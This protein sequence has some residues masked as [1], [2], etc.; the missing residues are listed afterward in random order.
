MPRVALSAWVPVPVFIEDEFVDRHVRIGAD[1]E[2]GF[3]DE[4]D[5]RLAVRPG[6]DAF[7][8]DD[9]LADHQPLHLT[10]RQRAAD[11]GVDGAADADPLLR[12]GGQR[13]GGK[14]R[15]NQGERTAHG[16]P[17]ALSYLQVTATTEREFVV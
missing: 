6:R 17:P 2:C 15:K 8:E 14:K 4:Q 9:V 11:G 3:V 7:V 16:E 10:P 13:K 12:R 1:A 5:L